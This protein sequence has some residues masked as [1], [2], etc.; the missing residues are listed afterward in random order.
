MEN[1]IHA[2]GVREV[3]SQS[4]C[5]VNL[6]HFG[7]GLLLVIASQEPAFSD[8]Q[9]KFPGKGSLSDYNKA[10]SVVSEANKLA[11]KEDY[12]RALE[13]DRQA[14]SIYPYDSLMY[15][16]MGADNKNSGNMVDAIKAFEQAIALEPNFEDAW[17]ALAGCYEHVTN[18]SQ[19]EKCLRKL[20]SLKPK[21]FGYLSTLG[22]VLRKQGRFEE[23]REY[24]I[25]AKS[26][27]AEQKSYKLLTRIMKLNDIHHTEAVNYYE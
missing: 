18:L 19:Q 14:I 22:D 15:F 11:D 23:A 3:R 7:L 26:L 10:C 2:S 6:V 17:Q 16:D 9:G 13:L 12:K 4:N 5:A 25:Q 1:N 21:A 8:S 20:I 27:P 24:L